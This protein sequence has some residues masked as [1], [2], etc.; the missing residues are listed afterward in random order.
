MRLPLVFAAVC[1]H[2]CTSL[3]AP[4]IY[5]IS[6][7]FQK[8]QPSTLS[9]SGFSAG[10]ASLLS[11]QPVL[12][13]KPFEAE[14][15]QSL[16]QPSL[17]Q[18]PRAVLAVQVAGV[19]SGAPAASLLDKHGLAATAT[20]ELVTESNAP[21]ANQLLA[22]LAAA[23]NSINRERGSSHV[24]LDYTGLQGCGDACIE[25]TLQA[26]LK[27]LHSKSMYQ[28]GSGPLK[29]KLTIGDVELD[30]TQVPARLWVVELATL[31]QTG[32]DAAQEHTRRVKQ[33]D[34]RSEDAVLLEATMIS[35]Q[36]LKARYGQDSAEFKAA[37][38]ATL[39]V[40]SLVQ[41]QVS[42]A[43]DGRVA[44]QLTF[45]GDVPQ[46]KDGLGSLLGWRESQRRLLLQ[47]GPTTSNTG[48]V[49]SNSAAAW[50]TGILFI[51]GTVA[52]FRCMMNM[53]FQR[54]TLLFSSAK[55]D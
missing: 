25:Q 36:A 47:A 16:L 40:I 42:K 27:E 30:L 32:L 29:G 12:P 4:S 39:R 22:A 46:G 8:T 43:W 21:P 14:Q 34:A 55:V 9:L 7:Y 5:Y 2:L 51:L 20:R 33:G 24:A 23:A 53:K 41:Q 28:A 1:C 44:T 26:L 18:R 6:D 10:L 19:D 52:A 35:L 17:F 45:L 31:Y 38:D 50:L 49:W 37:S 3:A 54:D 11:T 48:V 15:V 13:L